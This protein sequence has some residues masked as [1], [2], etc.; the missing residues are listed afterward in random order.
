MALTVFVEY[1]INF[2]P[3]TFLM[4]VALA[5]GFSVGVAA[6]GVCAGCKVF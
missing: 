4:G 6:A 1:L 2:I 3:A 5:A